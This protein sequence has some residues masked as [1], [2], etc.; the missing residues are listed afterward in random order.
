[1]DLRRLRGFV[2]IADLGSMAS[3]AA[4]LR[5]SQPA[6]SRQI[7]GLQDEL[8]VRLFERVGRRLSLTGAGE[9][10][11]AQARDLMARADSFRE[12]AQLMRRGDSG[13]L[14]VAASPQMIEAAFPEFLRS[15]HARHPGVR[16]KLT[17]AAD[18]EQL[19]YL[20]RGDVHLALNV[21]EADASRFGILPLVPMELL[22]AWDRSLGLAGG[23]AVE[24]AALGE[25]PLLLLKPVY[26]TRKLF[27][28]ACRLS[29]LEP[30]IHVESG[31]PHT[32]TAL[33]EAGFGAAIIPSTLRVE[34]RTLRIARLTFRGQPLQVAL[35]M[36]WDKR[37]PLPRYAEAFLSD[38]AEH[39]RRV[40]PFAGPRGGRARETL[41]KSST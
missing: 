30:N 28:A 17:E 24:V 16:V 20:E 26:T 35:A 21:A 37:R 9:E 40:L 18:A 27:D 6:L 19:T 39:L 25:L 2:T 8:G 4:R 33:A 5:I 7:A 14:R 36:L 15:Y 41:K 29:R 12:R 3:A 22:V 32:L 23:A 13:I 38:F 1:M 10:V 31:A 34:S 11:L